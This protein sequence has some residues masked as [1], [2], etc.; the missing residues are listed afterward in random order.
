MHNIGPFLRYDL[1][2]VKSN[3]AR[4][5]HVIIVSKAMLD[6]PVA[7]SAS[8]KASNPI[9]ERQVWRKGH[10]LPDL[11]KSYAESGCHPASSQALMDSRGSNTSTCLPV[12][13]TEMKDFHRPILIHR[14]M[15]P[16][17][18]RTPR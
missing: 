16:T 18:L 1:A 17:F 7:R 8:N 15:R 3:K 13:S 14:R 4:R 2:N 10:R 6:D 9:A 11:R 12:Q 5:Q